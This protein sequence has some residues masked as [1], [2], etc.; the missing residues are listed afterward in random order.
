MSTT[1][2]SIEVAQH[3]LGRITFKE[4]DT[5]K[6]PMERGFFDTPAAKSITNKTVPLYDVRAGIFSVSPVIS[7]ETHGFTAVKHSTALLLPANEGDMFMNAEAIEKI[8]IPE[9]EKIIQTLTGARKIIIIR[10]A[11]RSRE[12][13]DLV[14]DNQPPK[15]DNPT[16]KPGVDLSNYDYTR[17]T[18]NIVSRGQ[19][20]PERLAHL[21]YSPEGARQEIRQCRH[22]LRLAA[23]DIIAAEDQAAEGRSYE[24]RRYAVYSV[25]RP[26]KTVTRDP[27][28]V[29]DP[30]SIDGQDL[31]GFSTK[32][33]GING[34][35][36]SEGNVLDGRRAE[37]QRWLWLKN[38]QP[39]EVLILQFFD[40]HAEK[41][42]RPVGV[43]HGSPELIGVHND[44]LRESFEVRCVAFW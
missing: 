29:C 34:P 2:T 10:A 19:L 36:L 16:K 33:P 32:R 23:E 9:V 14:A 44:D 1:T 30:N 3:Q 39:E 24:G 20:G 15:E 35:Y 41:E 40:S 18:Y 42:G 11:L 28:A 25:W 26:L 4:P 17:P 6:D 8:Y 13:G 37:R 21:D 12:P 7:L 43:A 38:Q 5:S 22:D 31:L 27:L